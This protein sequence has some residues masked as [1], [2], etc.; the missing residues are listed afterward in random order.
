MIAKNNIFNIRHA[1][2]TKWTGQ[3]GQNK[4]FVEFDT[5]EHAIRAWLVLMRTYRKKY[6]C[7]TIEK[8]ITSFAPPIENNTRAYINFCVGYTG[9]KR[10]DQ[11]TLNMD[12]CRL[13]VA[14]AKIETNSLITAIEI[15]DVAD[16]YNIKIVKQ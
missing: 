10:N 5:R 14:M 11:I 12:Y 3:I 15:W 4:G 2:Q 16:T 8:I 13:G 9:L 7:D 6:G 1:A